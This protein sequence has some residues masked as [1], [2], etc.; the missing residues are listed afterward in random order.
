MKIF[1]PRFLAAVAVAVALSGCSQQPT[2]NVPSDG[3]KQTTSREVPVPSDSMIIDVRSAEEFSTGHLQGAVNIDV[4]GP[5][6]DSI[7][8]GLDPN[9]SYLLYCRSGNRSAVAAERM[10]QAGIVN[11]TDLGSV[12]VAASATGI[13]VVR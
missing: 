3:S 11:I 1:R 13:E 2:T 8:S 9:G 4:N 5:T 6:F 7:I 12:E 10:R